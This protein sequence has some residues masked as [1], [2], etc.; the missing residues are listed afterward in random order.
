MNVQKQ[1]PGL[2]EKLAG[3]GHPLVRREYGLRIEKVDAGAAE[4]VRLAEEGLKV[5]PLRA[6][7]KHRNK[8]GWWYADHAG[9]C[10]KKY[11]GTV[12]SLLFAAELGAPVGEERLRA[13][14]ARFLES[15]F[16]PKTGAFES[17]ARASMTIACFVAHACYFLTYFGFGEDERVESAWRWLARN[18]GADG[19]MKCMVMDVCLN[20][21]CTMA[22]P[23]VLKAASLLTPARRK[24]L[25]GDALERAIQR[26]REVDIDRYQPVET[27]EWNKRIAGKRI[28]EIRAAKAAMKLSGDYRRKPSWMRFQFPLHYDSDVLEALIYLG[29][30][31]V[32]ANAV[33]KAAAQRVLAAKG[34]DGWE[35]GRS[36]KGK[37]WADVPMEDDW[38]T[39]RALEALSYYG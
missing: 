34:E 37:M 2:C 4:M 31:R 20:A 13:S 27:G 32:P 29:R 3:H 11:E 22:V 18:A 26:L 15:C 25:L 14:C 5:E 19:G 10:Y 12:W 21:T 8:E 30:L 17:G 6:I 36:L 9:G 33:L 16:S 35:A 24:S 1:F 39:V 28:A 38:V 7:L 23:K